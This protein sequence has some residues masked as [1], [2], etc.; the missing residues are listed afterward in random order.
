V[1]FSSPLEG[2]IKH[3]PSVFSLPFPRRSRSRSA[4][5]VGGARL[6]LS[7]RWATT[8]SGIAKSGGYK[9][10]G[11]AILLRRRGLKKKKLIAKPIAKHAKAMGI[12][13]SV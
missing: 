11:T 3:H 5:L 12:K 2:A 13:K 8:E 9:L 10:V 6:N 7:I 1:C 4:G